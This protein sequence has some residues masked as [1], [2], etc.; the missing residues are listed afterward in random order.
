VPAIT[1][2][3]R[4]GMSIVLVP[5]NGL[6]LDQVQGSENDA[7]GIESYNIDKHHFANAKSL[8]ERLRHYTK[9]EAEENCYTY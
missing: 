1:G 2:A 3:I 6:G 7:F 9:E 8:Q 5:L 4:S